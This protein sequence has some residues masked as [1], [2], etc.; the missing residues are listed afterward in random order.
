MRVFHLKVNVEGTSGLDLYVEMCEGGIR[1]A[2]R[3]QDR[4]SQARP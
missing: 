1:K 3:Q 2:D 4:E